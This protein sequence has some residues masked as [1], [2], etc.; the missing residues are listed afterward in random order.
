PER[1]GAIGGAAGGAPPL[2]LAPTGGGRGAK[3]QDATLPPP[4]RLAPA[5][6][7]LP[8][9]APPG[10][11]TDPPPVLKKLPPLKP[12]LT[13]DAK[14]EAPC[15]PLLHVTAQTA[16]SLLIHG[17]RD[18]LVPIAHSTN[19]LAGMQEAKAV[20]KLVT[21]EGAGHSFTPQQDRA[22]VLP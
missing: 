8:P 13:F 2:M 21:V 11:T 4:T 18:E 20:C 15:S 6:P 9:P 7:P 1:L 10:R 14:Q 19:F 12:P 22:I 5:L 16:P 3:A 17:D